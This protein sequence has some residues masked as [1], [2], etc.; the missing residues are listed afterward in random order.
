MYKLRNLASRAR[1][2]PTRNVMSSVAY[3]GYSG[4]D[5]SS[6]KKLFG[7]FLSGLAGLALAITS[8]DNCGIVGVAGDTDDASAF[9]LEGLVILRNRGYDSAGIATISK[10]GSLS[11][12]K[13]ASRDSTCDS[14]D[15][16]KSHSGEHVGHI[17]GIAH[18]RW[19]THGGKTDANA[20]PHVDSKHRIALI[21]NGTIN[22]SYDLK[23]ELQ[24]AGIRFTSE[25][26]TEVIAQLVGVYLDKGYDTK[27]AVER[28]LAMCIVPLSS[29][30]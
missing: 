15:L 5:S 25:T 18:T 9:L 20:H 27:E 12:T 30:G 17:T 16:V 2:I 14:I 23:K 26:D 13:F 21:H 1:L 11:V 24:A 10:E 19:A 3:A 4:S 22:N 6:T 29:C 8:A 28:A 7:F